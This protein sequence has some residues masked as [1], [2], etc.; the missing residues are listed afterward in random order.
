MGQSPRTLWLQE[1]QDPLFGTVSLYRL[2]HS[3]VFT[4]SFEA[5]LSSKAAH[6]QLTVLRDNPRPFCAR[7]LQLTLRE[8]GARLL[9]GVEQEYFNITLAD[10]N[11]QLLKR[12][13]GYA[14]D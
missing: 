4:M 10:M 8:Q 12:G 14:P 1:H 6:R 3:Q 5:E 13:S 7:I 9:A 11:R 2:E